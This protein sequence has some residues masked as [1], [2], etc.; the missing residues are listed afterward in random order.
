MSKTYENMSKFRVIT[1]TGCQY[2]A[3]IVIHPWRN[4][5]RTFNRPRVTY[6]PYNDCYEKSTLAEE[7]NKTRQ[8]VEKHDR[9]VG[10]VTRYAWHTTGL[11]KPLQNSLNMPGKALSKLKKQSRQHKSQ[12]KKLKNVVTSATWKISFPSLSRTYF[13][14]S[15]KK[16]KSTDFS[17]LCRQLT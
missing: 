8:L 7:K 1:K 13:E 4:L 12:D 6:L 16:M 5:N 2:M 17:K 15:W 11:T 10:S 9:Q 3:T 14:K